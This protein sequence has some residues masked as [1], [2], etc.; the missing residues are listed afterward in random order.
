MGRVF[1]LYDML[2]NVAYVLGPAIA[3]PFLPATGK[4][5]RVVLVDRGAAT[6]SRPRSYAA[7]TRSA[8]RPAERIPS[9]RGPPQQLLR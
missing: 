8:D 5:Y 2:Y 1:S 9:A 6:W 3:V 7:L 4:S